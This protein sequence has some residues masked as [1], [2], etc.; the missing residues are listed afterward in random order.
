[1]RV[2]IAENAGKLHL[3]P[4]DV[5]R[6]RLL[7][8]LCMK[9]TRGWQNRQPNFEPAYYKGGAY[10]N[11]ERFNRVGLLADPI[12]KDFMGLLSACSFGPFQMMYPVACE[13]GFTEF[14]LELAD[15]RINIEFAIR[16]IN[17]RCIPFVTAKKAEDIVAQ[18]A[19]G[20]N[21]GN[22]VDRR[23]PQIYIDEVLA[24]YRQADLFDHLQ[25]LRGYYRPAAPARATGNG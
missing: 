4:G 14:P 1:M 16:Y 19:D 13:L 17:A 15:P 3:D 25:T 21:S 2:L 12:L 23:V 5:N 8:A 10:F 22:P 7:A 6:E 9:E 20:Y 24:Y 18:V 11:A